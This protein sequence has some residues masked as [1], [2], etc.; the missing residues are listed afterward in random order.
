[1]PDPCSLVLAG[2]LGGT[3]FRVGIFK[4]EPDHGITRLHFAKFRS[5][6]HHSLVE[7]VRLFLGGITLKHPIQ[8]ACFGVPGP[9]VAGVIVASNLGWKVDTQTLPRLLGIQKVAVLNDLES[10]AYGLSALHQTD[11]ATLQAGS[12]SNAGNQCVIAPGTGLG[13]AGLFWDGNRHHPWACEGGHADFAPTDDLQRELLDYLRRDYGRVSFERIVSGMGITNIYRFLRDSG[14]C[15]ENPVVAREMVEQ[16]PA[17]VIDI[18][19][20]DGSCALCRSTM[21]LFVQS[22]GAE[23]ANMALKTMAT[24]GV[25]LAG[26][27]PPKI[28]PLLR[29]PLFLESFLNKGR[30]RSVLET[31]PLHVVLNDETALLGSARRAI[32]LL[33]TK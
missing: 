7:M 8:A 24:G 23:A 25:F 12:G 18:H 30:L 28:L 21:D 20:A 26:G 29:R 9:N 17:A 5:A 19:A 2:D 6:D 13:E 32:R 10:T 16:D 3:N 14:H 4:E 33:E 11:L 27:I 1:M 15:V 22:L 31:M